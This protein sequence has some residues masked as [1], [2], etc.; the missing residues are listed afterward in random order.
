[1]SRNETVLTIFVASPGDVRE[2]RI[3]LEEIVKEINQQWSKH[4][5]TRYE[6][7]KWETNTHPDIGTSAQEV[8]NNQIGH[9]YDIFIGIFWSRF[10]TKTDNA[11]SGTEEEY[12]LA[13][14]KYT[15]NKNIKIAIYFKDMPLNPSSIDPLQLDKVQKYMEQIKKQGLYYWTFTSPDDF[16][17][18]IRSHLVQILQ[19][20][21][22]YPELVVKQLV[23]TKLKLNMEYW[24]I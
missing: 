3:I 23:K 19:T 14:E 16:R 4:V 12:N 6:L 18:A 8:I 24:I 21:I 5:E 10:G 20:G 15:K 22:K 13:I 9:D 2:E 17:N 11:E 1:M 7:I